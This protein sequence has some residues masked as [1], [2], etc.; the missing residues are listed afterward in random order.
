[1][2]IEGIVAEIT[3]PLS[4]KIKLNDGSVIRRHVDHIRIHHSQPQQDC[5]TETIDDSFMFPSPKKNPSCP[6]NV[7][8][9]QQSVLR[10]STRR[11]NPPI[12][13]S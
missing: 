4:Y 1:M 9:P 5:S 12:C 3:G 10:R 11:Q 6:T 2:W 8:P 7:T 13:F